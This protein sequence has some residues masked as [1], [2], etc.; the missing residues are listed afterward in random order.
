MSELEW[1]AEA[2]REAKAAKEARNAARQQEIEELQQ[3][4][5]EESNPSSQKLGILE[6]L[7]GWASAGLGNP[8]ELR[9]LSCSTQRK[10]RRNERCGASAIA[11]RKVLK[12]E[13]CSYY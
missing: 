3:I 11:Q 1:E 6:E 8:H 5:A 12:I 2:A 7:G 13:C 10:L 9:T 4:Q